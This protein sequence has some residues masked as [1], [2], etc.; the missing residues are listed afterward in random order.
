[1]KRVVVD[2]WKRALTGDPA[3]RRWKS[4]NRSWRFARMLQRVD[5]VPDAQEQIRR[6]GLAHRA[7]TPRLN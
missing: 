3:R 7:G 2:G 4:I 6:A 1:M 5:V